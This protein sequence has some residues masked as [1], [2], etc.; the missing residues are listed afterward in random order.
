MNYPIVTLDQSEIEL[1]MREGARAAEEC[2]NYKNYNVG[3]DPLTASRIG[4]AAEIAVHKFLGA[5]NWRG[6]DVTLRHNPDVLDVEVRCTKQKNGRLILNERDL[7]KSSRKYLNVRCLG[8]ARFELVG[9][10]YGYEVMI[11]AN[12][13]I[14]P[15]FVEKIWRVEDIEL[16]NV[17]T[18]RGLNT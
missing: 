16:R 5:E 8:D 3:I 6:F 2:K 10:L 15:Q 11:D 4:G 12:R 13:F 9:W 18:L 1:A 14:R 17:S 7:K